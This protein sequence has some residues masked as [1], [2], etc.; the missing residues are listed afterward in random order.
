MTSLLPLSSLC[1]R[2]LALLILG[3]VITRALALLAGLRYITGE[4]VWLWQLLDLEILRHHLVRGLFH[5]HS[6]PPLFNALIG[7]A[8]KFGGSSFGE[9]ILAFQLLLGMCAVISV[10]LT[11]IHL[12]V[13]PTFSLLLSSLLLFNPAQILFEFDPLYTEIV[14]ALHCF[15]ALA[16]ACYVKSRSSFALYWFVGLSVC[17]TLL[18]SS[19]QW[20]WIVAML[21]L[22]WWQLPESRKQIWKV[23]AIGVVMTLLWPAKNYVLVHHFASTTWGPFSMSKHWSTERDRPPMREWIREGLLP[24]FEAPTDESEDGL[25]RR[26]KEQ[27]LAPSTGAPELDDITKSIGGAPNWNSLSMLRMRDAQAKD[28]AFLLRRDPKTYA[29]SVI[30]GVRRYFEPSSSYLTLFQLAQWNESIAQYQQMAPVDRIVRRVCCN[31]F[32]FPSTI[33]H[34]SHPSL[35]AAIQRI[36]MGAVLV[37]GLVVGCLLSFGICRTLWNGDRDRKVVTMLMSV[38]IVYV[39]LV[40]A[41]L[42]VGENMQFRFE[43]HALVMMVAAVFLQ[44][45]WDWR[46]NPMRRSTFHL[47][48]PKQWPVQQ[49]GVYR[50]IHSPG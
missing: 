8:E 23:G 7:L 5:L 2:H 14:Y 50:S 15:I 48:V 37:Y 39:F 26:L 34:G 43:T 49:N 24:T 28:I 36:C 6:Q 33:N 11:L 38:T 21:G 45:I 46:K 35:K 47:R 27:W 25:Q 10:Y 42:E 44:Q 41:L 40:V 9:V 30:R 31:V 18:R 22:L 13:A 4:T 19:Y 29:Y 32:G 17:L 12:D 16:V 20:I 3:F 1:R